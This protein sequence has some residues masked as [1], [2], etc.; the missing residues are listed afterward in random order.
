MMFTEFKLIGHPFIGVLRRSSEIK[1]RPVIIILLF[2]KYHKLFEHYK[3]H[4]IIK[5]ETQ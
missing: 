4:I 3:T 5:K 2:I 1:K